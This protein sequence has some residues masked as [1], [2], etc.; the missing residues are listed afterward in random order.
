MRPKKVPTVI[1]IQKVLKK[2]VNP[3]QNSGW[4]PKPAQNVKEKE[5]ARKLLQEITLLDEIV[6]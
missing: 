3:K 6:I 5:I 1:V 2:H 4:I